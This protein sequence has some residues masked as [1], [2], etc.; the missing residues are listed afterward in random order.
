[1]QRA[2]QKIQAAQQREEEFALDVLTTNMHDENVVCA[3]LKSM[4]V[5]AISEEN[6][7]KIDKLT[8]EQR[9][10]CQRV[11]QNIIELKDDVPLLIAAQIGALIN[12]VSFVQL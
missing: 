4:M 6:L 8:A 11:I 2:N 9:E 1:M 12:Q 5:K 3:Q 10:K 7:S